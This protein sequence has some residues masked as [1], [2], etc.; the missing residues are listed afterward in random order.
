MSPSATCKLAIDVIDLKMLFLD[1][2]E[3]GCSMQRPA[4]SQRE[5][6]RFQMKCVIVVTSDGGV[7]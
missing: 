1:R 7:V 3:T 2:N 5:A 4:P 6:C